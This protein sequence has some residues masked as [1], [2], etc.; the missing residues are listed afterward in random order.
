LGT[1]PTKPHILAISVPECQIRG[2][3]PLI[4]RAGRLGSPDKMPE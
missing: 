2:F 1:P 4:A 3:W